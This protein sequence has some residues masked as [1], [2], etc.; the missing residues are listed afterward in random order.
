MQKSPDKPQFDPELAKRILKS[1]NFNEILAYAEDYLAKNKIEIPEVPETLVEE[2]KKEYSRREFGKFLGGAILTG[3]GAGIGLSQIQLATP[4]TALETKSSEKPKSAEIFPPSNPFLGFRNDLPELMVWAKRAGA[5]SVRVDGDR[6]DLSNPEALNEAKKLG[7]NVLYIFHPTKPLP[8]EQI[9][10]QL[11]K[12]YKSGADIT[13]EI[14]NEPDDIYVPRWQNHDLDSFSRFTALVLDRMEK[15]KAAGIIPPDAKTVIGALTNQ[16]NS[17]KFVASL[18]KAGI[19][20]IDNLTFA[21]HAYDSPKDVENRVATLK[22]ATKGAAVIITEMGTNNVGSDNQPIMESVD[23]ISGM[24]TTARKTTD[25][26]I[27]IH[28]LPYTE[29]D[30]LTK[31]GYGFVEMSGTPL[32]SFNKLKEGIEYAEKETLSKK[33]ADSISGI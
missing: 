21:V 19:K 6:V 4:T 8:A 23:T 27:F 2:P 5:S 9:D 13:L 16:N 14:G 10:E 18:T 1:P 22:K 12:I 29:R 3:I 11:E 24:Y 30:P 26:P 7:L 25:N 33:T 31:Q 28:Q 20:N 32:A 17:E 15:L